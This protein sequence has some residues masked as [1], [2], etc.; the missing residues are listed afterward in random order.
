MEYSEVQLHSLY[1]RM[2]EQ[3][4]NNNKFQQNPDLRILALR[5]KCAVGGVLKSG[6]FTKFS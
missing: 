1:P 4:V 5:I 2:R 3:L 6:M